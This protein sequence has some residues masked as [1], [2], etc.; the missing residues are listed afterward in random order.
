MT[1]TDDF[2][3][4]LEAELDKGFAHSRVQPQVRADG[5]Q[6]LI[7]RPGRSRRSAANGRPFVGKAA[8]ALAAATLSLGT[9]GAAAATAVT[10]SVNPQAW[11]QQVENAVSDCKA[12]L[13]PGQ[14]GIGECV[15]A[16]AKQHGS[17]NSAG[18]G[19]GHGKKK[20][21]PVVSPG[22]DDNVQ[23]D[24]AHGHGGQPKS[25]KSQDPTPK[26]APDGQ[27]SPSNP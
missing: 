23:P 6:S 9:V 27:E 21:H 11:G 2:D 1:P 3:N 15:S 7:A 5:Y 14:H 18:H 16:F 13:S 25:G 22:P 4:W 20:S 17:A 12:A 8:M 24:S 19:H 10:H 26:G